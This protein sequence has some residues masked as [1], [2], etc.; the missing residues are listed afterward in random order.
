MPG[1]PELYFAEDGAPRS[2]RFG[3]IYYSL[4]DGLMESRAVFLDGCGLPEAWAEARVFSVLELGFG[5]GLNIVALVER[6]AA[7]RTPGGHLHVFTIE[8]FLMPREAAARALSAWPELSAVADRVLEQWPKARRGF[9]YMDFPEWGVSIT[10][11]LMEVRDALDAWDGR[12]DAV[13]LDGFSPA[14]NPDMW[15][16]D[17]LMRVAGH[18]HPG[19][20]LATFTVAGF[21]RRGLQ[22]AGF[23]VEKRPGYGR[24]RERLEAVFPG[25]RA[26][27]QP[28]RRVAVVG[29][30]I[31]GAA[32]IHH[33]RLFGVEADLFDARGP[34][35]GASG[36]AAGLVTPRLDAGH[37]DVTGLFADALYYA[38]A[39]Y[40]RVAP[41]AIVHEGTWLCEGPRDAGRFDKLTRLPQHAEGDIARVA[42][43]PGVAR[44][45]LFFKAALAVRPPEIVAGLLAGQSLHRQSIIDWR[46]EA[47]GTLTLTDEAGE[48]RGYDAVVLAC[49]AGIF[50]LTPTPGL[51]PVRGQI[52]QVASDDIPPAPVSWGGYIVPLNDGFV[53]GAT[54]DRD[55]V[56][57]DIRDG[58][59]TRNLAL[60]AKA[61]PERAEAAAGLPSRSRAAVRVASRDHLPRAGE[62]APG[63]FVVTGLGGRGLCLA[64]L[65]A[66]AVMARIAGLPGQLPNAVKNLLSPEQ[67]HAPG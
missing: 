21:V 45:G 2:G 44:G 43:V 49:G 22:A 27:T 10:L 33:A 65:M 28:R 34:A 32:L 64:P 36:N 8:G 67:P 52:E 35:A 61:M 58:D 39:L 62:I 37:D 41:G 38:A 5:T 59:R 60:L 3:D 46:R 17:V 30:G 23:T 7:H 51:Q 42:A 12:A 63:L 50:D 24:K 18:A 16:E 31:V 48:A 25:E 40:R 19:A 1:D 26:R 9:H 54:H 66:R 14:L 53:F 47:D 6:W 57:T 55:D 15:A 11:A 13:F 4:Q 20:R 29:A 56:A